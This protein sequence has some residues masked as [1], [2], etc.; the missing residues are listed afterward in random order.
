[1]ISPIDIKLLQEAF[2]NK[3]NSLAQYIID[4]EPY[5]GDEKQIIFDKIKSIAQ[6]DANECVQISELIQA[7]DSVPKVNPH[8]HFVSDL[9]YLSIDYLSKVL[10]QELTKEKLQYEEAKAKCINIETFKLFED[11]VKQIENAL[12]RLES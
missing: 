12:K 11:L 3:H 5:I 7:Y 8:P 1:M 2:D 4:A 10:C 9:N 6:V